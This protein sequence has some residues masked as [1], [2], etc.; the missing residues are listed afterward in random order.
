MDKLNILRPDVICKATGH[1]KEQVELV[2]KLLKKGCAYETPEAVYFDVTKFS[3][4]GKLFGQKLDEKKIAVRAEVQVGEYKRHPQDFALWFKRVGRFADHEMHWPS[5]WGEGFPG[6]HIEC[7]AMSMKYLG[8]QFDIHTGGEDHIAVHH[9]NEIAQSEAATGKKPFVRH[10]IHHIFLMVEGKK[11]SKSLG[12]FYKIEDLE[13]R[14]FNPLALRYLFLTTHY[15]KRLN[16]TWKGLEAAQRALD[17]LYE[18]A[19]DI[20]KRHSASQISKV[21]IKYQ[22]E[23]K[24]T[25]QEEFVN[26]LSNDLNTPR[27]LAVVWKLIKDENVA[28]ADKYRLLLDFD[29]VLGLKLW[30]TR[31]PTIVEAPVEVKKMVEQREEMRKQKKWQEADRLRLQIEKS[32]FIVEDTAEG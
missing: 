32:G 27:A 15:R 28:P 23:K 5:P 2:K 14:G 16:F 30:E 25:Y 13:A 19:S 18:K 1:I 6:W 3:D 11:M 8:E 7:S 17:K 12:N 20:K 21:K 22:K 31:S 10:W 29:K 9:P 26:Y 4:Y 24:N